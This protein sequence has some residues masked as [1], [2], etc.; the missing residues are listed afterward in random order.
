[1]KTGPGFKIDTN[2]SQGKESKIP[3]REYSIVLNR[4]LYAQSPVSLLEVPNTIRVKFCIT[5]LFT[6]LPFQIYAQPAGTSIIRVA[7]AE[8]LQAIYKF[9]DTP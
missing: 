7:S 3:A 4:P 1:M 8:E 9:E 6:T 5:T 2:E